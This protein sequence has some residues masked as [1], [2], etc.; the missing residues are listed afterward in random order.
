MMAKHQKAFPV[1]VDED[2]LVT[3]MGDNSEMVL[4]VVGAFEP[5]GPPILDKTSIKVS[6]RDGGLVEHFGFL[7]DHEC[8][9]G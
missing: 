4:E 3:A 6:Q 7:F 5:K 1:C 2:L 9:V 8:S